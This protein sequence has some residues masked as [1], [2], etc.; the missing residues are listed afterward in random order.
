[1]EAFV[2]SEMLSRENEYFQKAES[3]VWPPRSSPYFGNFLF[4]L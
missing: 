4:C 2:S 3:L 1:M